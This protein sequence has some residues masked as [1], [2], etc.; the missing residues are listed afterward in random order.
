MK[1][2]KGRKKEK[3]RH[4]IWLYYLEIILIMQLVYH[5]ISTDYIYR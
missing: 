4:Y 1:I 2:R 5:C 3:A